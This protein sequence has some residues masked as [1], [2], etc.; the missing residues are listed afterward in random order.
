MFYIAIVMGV[1]VSC[2]LISAIVTLAQHEQRLRQLEDERSE[3][4]VHN[5]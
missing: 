2:L 1:I 5:A 4:S 3:H